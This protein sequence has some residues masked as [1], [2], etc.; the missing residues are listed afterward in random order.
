MPINPEAPRPIHSGHSAAHLSTGEA[1]DVTHHQHNPE[2]AAF[3][4]ALGMQNS[5]STDQAAFLLEHM[6]KNQMSTDTQA[7]ASQM[8][9]DHWEN[10]LS[11]GE[12]LDDVAQRALAFLGSPEGEKLFNFFVKTFAKTSGQMFP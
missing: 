4:A 11:A 9:T 6:I 1:Q 2:L 7:L 5:V 10:N 12:S 8:R 3:I